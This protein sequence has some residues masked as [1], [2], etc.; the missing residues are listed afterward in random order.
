MKKPT[1][2]SAPDANTLGDLGLQ[3]LPVGH[4]SSTA[5][6][7]L[8]LPLR[9]EALSLFRLPPLLL[10]PAQCQGV[11]PGSTAPRGCYSLPLAPGP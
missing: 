9:C 3:A 4:L 2:L 10:L 1:R 8:L 11:G 7:E 6:G 5:G